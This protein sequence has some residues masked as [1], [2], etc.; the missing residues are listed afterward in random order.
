M[1]SEEKVFDEHGIHVTDIIERLGKLE[2]LV[3]TE[4]M[5]HNGSGRGDDPPGVTSVT[6]AKH[7]SRRSD[8]VHDSLMKVKR[9]KDNRS[10]DACS[11]E[12]LQERIK[13]ID[14][15]L[16]VI[17]SDMLLLSDYKSFAE[18]AS[19]LKEASFEIRVAIKRRLKNLNAESSRRPKLSEVKLPKVSVLTFDGKVLNWKNF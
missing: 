19:A 15:D 11:L 16:Q 2:D 4:P 7:L 3:S 9:D 12:G 6:E 17:K 14:A 18:K 13:S 8:Q 1:N 10:L 5:M